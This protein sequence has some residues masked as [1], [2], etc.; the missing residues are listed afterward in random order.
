MMEIAN[1][2]VEIRDK[3]AEIEDAEDEETVARLTAE[4]EQLK[5]RKEKL[6]ERAREEDGKAKAIKKA[7]QFK[8]TSEN[9]LSQEWHDRR[10]YA[11]RKAGVSHSAAWAQE[12]KRRRVKDEE[13]QNDILEGVETEAVEDIGGGKV[14]ILTGDARVA[15]KSQLKQV[16]QT[17]FVQVETKEDEVKVME[18][19]RLNLFAKR[20][21]HMTPQKKLERCK[22]DHDVAKYE[23]ANLC[24]QFLHGHCRRLTKCKVEREICQ[25]LKRQKKVKKKSKAQTD[26]R[27]AS[28]TS[29]PADSDS[30]SSAM[31]QENVKSTVGLVEAKDVKVKQEKVPQ[32]EQGEWVSVNFD[33]GAAGRLVDVHRL[34]VSGSAVAKKNV[35]ILDGNEGWIIP[36]DSKIGKGV[37]AARDDLI[38]QNYK[39]AK[40]VYEKKGIFLFDLWMDKRT[41]MDGVDAKELGAAQGGSQSPGF[42]RQAQKQP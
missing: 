22:F 30:D 12:K 41:K 6:K 17:K 8:L 26:Q 23:K 2:D 3:A 31:E 4:V 39:E 9:V 35:V 38:N 14:R 15:K 32:A 1:L 34:L 36:R 7:G 13:C 33:T 20:L 25:V 24:P 5:D 40:M 21:R 10:Y 19:K 27:R 29:G 42:R 37:R 18:K 16:D 28:R 11:A